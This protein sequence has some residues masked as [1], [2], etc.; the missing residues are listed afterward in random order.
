MLIRMPMMGPSVSA[1]PMP[2]GQP[3]GM[4]NKPLFPSAAAIVS[5]TFSDLNLN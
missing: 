3:V 1:G 5:Y 2:P 4:T